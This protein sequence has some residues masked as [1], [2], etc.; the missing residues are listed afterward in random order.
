MIH[1]NRSL[2]SAKTAY[3]AQ[4]EHP[5]ECQNCVIPIAVQKFPKGTH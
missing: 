4:T 5:S 2:K 1:D 3:E